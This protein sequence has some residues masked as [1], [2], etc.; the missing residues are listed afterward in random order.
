MTV[1]PTRDRFDTDFASQMQTYRGFVF[2]LWV[3]TLSALGILALI[4]YCFA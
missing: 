3:V 1:I 2:G 4:A